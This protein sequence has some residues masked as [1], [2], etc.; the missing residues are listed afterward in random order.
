MNHGTTERL[1]NTRLRAQVKVL[2]LL[3]RASSLL[4]FAEGAVFE[5]ATKGAFLS[6]FQSLGDS[7]VYARG[8]EFPELSALMASLGGQAHDVRFSRDLGKESWGSQSGMLSQIGACALAGFRVSGRRHVILLCGAP[9][10]RG[11]RDSDEHV[12][13]LLLEGIRAHL[14]R[15]HVEEELRRTDERFRR[16]F[17]L[18]QVGTAILSPE[19]TWTIVNARLASLL[20]RSADELSRLTWE[21]VTAPDELPRERLLFRRMLAGEQEGYRIEKAFLLP[22]GSRLPALISTRVLLRGEGEVDA[23]IALIEDLSERRR[24][25]T[26]HAQMQ[27][28]LL[29]TQKLESLGL[30]AG[31]IA[32]DF[33]NLLTGILGNAH[34]VQLELGETPEHTAHAPLHSLLDATQR[35]A[36][37]T[38]QLLAYSGQRGLRAR[39]LGLSREV[40]E[41]SSLL[42]SL[43]P[44]KIELRLDLGVQLPLVVADSSQVQQVIMN[45]VI[46]GAEACGEEAGTVWIRTGTAFLEPFA[47]GDFA[48]APPREG[49]YVWIEVLD[50][51]QGMP[52]ETLARIFDPFFSTKFTGRGLGL[53]AVLGIVRG[54]HG[55][56]SVRSTPGQ[57]SVFRAYFPCAED[58]GAGVDDGSGVQR[59][60]ALVI[61]DEPS[62]RGVCCA[63]LSKAGWEV[64]AAASGHEGLALGRR[65]DA[66]IAIV[67]MTMPDMDGVEASAGLRRLRPDLPILYMSGFA[68][69]PTRQRLPAEGSYSFLH[70]PFTPAQFLQA[71]AEAIESHSPEGSK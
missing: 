59:Q 4:G 55:A 12:M 42:D 1:R 64:H 3:L 25:E 23:V 66:Q 35:A 5:E 19:G 9:R 48:L 46:N 44:K 17:H 7:A 6:V 34:L 33:N 69:G 14:E 8:S 22:D 32:H 15:V 70:K 67:D 21:D 49:T 24:I 61:D 36:G 2:D 51:G 63:V 43:I 38:R 52:A 50:T 11:F 45:L 16:F 60:I 28:Q 39:E 53:A 37:L 41:L 65:F 54:H 57:G 47:R 29:Q 31:G 58:A 62:V 10:W 71:I 13:A 40:Q 18:S 30:M 20:R 27:E 68:E 26:E 56:I